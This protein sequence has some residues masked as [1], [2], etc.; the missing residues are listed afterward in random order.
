MAA[1]FANDKESYETFVRDLFI[2]KPSFNIAYD[3]NK[4]CNPN[5]LSYEADEAEIMDFPH[6]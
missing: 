5:D 1:R 6:S 2:N 3:L 4:W